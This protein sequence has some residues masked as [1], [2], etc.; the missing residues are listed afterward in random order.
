MEHLVNASNQGAGSPSQANP[1]QQQIVNNPLIDPDY[2][3]FLIQ[4]QVQEAMNSSSARYTL[5]EFKKKHADMIPVFDG[6]P[7]K[8]RG[9]IETCQSIVDRFIDVEDEDNFQN[10]E[11][12]KTIVSRIQGPA[13]DM[14]NNHTLTDFDDIKQALLETYS[15]KRDVFTLCHELTG[16]RHKEHETPF[17]FL[18]RIKIK[19]NLIVAYLRNHETVKATREVLVT[20]Y[21]NLALRTLLLFLRE[22]LGS[23]LRTRQPKSLGEALSIITN[24]YQI[25]QY[26][27]TS[28]NKQHSNKNNHKNGADSK[29]QGGS[30][31]YVSQNKNSYNPKSN[32]QNFNK[33][34]SGQFVKHNAPN[35]N[36]QYKSNNY[37]SN[38]PQSTQVQNAKPSSGIYQSKTT[39]MSWQSI[40]PNLNNVDDAEDN[41]PGEPVENE[42]EDYNPQDEE[43]FLEEPMDPQDST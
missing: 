19:L 41:A 34:N 42:I 28:F 22:P 1:G 37:P 15:D 43:Y 21:Q 16:L 2:I 11:V 5:P 32:Y 4:R 6:K 36:T 12:I 9:F 14:L 27:K 13:S 40:N 17:E 7:E 24:D 10:E 35:Q 30:S 18:E 39:P 38:K 26:Q 31:A 23:Q 8:L 20:H 25:L 3:K 33:N 29:N